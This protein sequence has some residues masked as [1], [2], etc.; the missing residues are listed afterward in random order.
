MTVSELIE[1]LAELDPKRPVMI[2]ADGILWQVCS[3]T[4]E[5][6]GNGWQT[7]LP[8]VVLDADG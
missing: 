1:R 2:G 4:L 3:V 5:P 7:E 8:I 6:E